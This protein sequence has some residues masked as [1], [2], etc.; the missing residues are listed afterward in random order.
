MLFILQVSIL[1]EQIYN[2]LLIVT[3]SFLPDVCLKYLF[4][5]VSYIFTISSIRLF[6]SIKG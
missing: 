1:S 2:Y 3:P 5:T 6:Q 4:P